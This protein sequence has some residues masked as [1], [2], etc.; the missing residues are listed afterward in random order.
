MTFDDFMRLPPYSLAQRE[1]ER[2]LLPAL[3]DVTAHH[4]TRCPPF[5]R[6]V[7]ASAPAYAEARHLIDL[8]FLPVS[9]FKTHGLQSV[10]STDVISLLT[11]SGTST[12][13][14]SRIA[15]DAVTADRQASALTS[16]V[17]HV[18]GSRRLPMLVVDSKAVITSPALMSARGAGV[19]GMMR[20]GRQPFFAL[21]EDMKPDVRG[22]RAFLDRFGQAPF[23][24]FG[25]TFVVWRFFQQVLDQG[26]DLSNGILL[27]GGGWKRLQQEAVD[28]AT[29][30]RVLREKSGLCRV[31]N[32]YGMV[33]QLGGIFLEGDDGLLHPPLFGD[34]II[35]DV[36]T[37]QEAP[38]GQPGLIQVLSIVPLSYPGHSLLTEDIGMLHHVDGASSGWRGKAFSVLGR[39]PQV[40][41]RG[42]SDAVD[43]GALGD[44]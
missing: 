4:C 6:V 42:C 37:L 20:F 12:G 26:L 14:T 43:F 7:A 18:L 1:K 13:E 16:L 11:S 8:P 34:I 44:G 38:L 29:F 27:H 30:K 32:F 19:L 23:F 33:E 39:A 21:D 41:L 22:V 15:V 10:G 5:A 17:G 28:N 24:L 40:T 31:H 9:L 3:I 25:F 35:R 2:L 36:D